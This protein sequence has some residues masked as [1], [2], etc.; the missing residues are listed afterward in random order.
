MVEQELFSHIF[1][2]CFV[3][4]QR[5][6]QV[7]SEKAVVFF[8]VRVPLYLSNCVNKQNMDYWWGTYPRKFQKRLLHGDEIIIW[9]VISADSDI[10]SYIFDDDQVFFVTITYD[11]Y[12]DMLRLFLGLNLNDDKNFLEIEILFSP[13]R[14]CSSHCKTTSGNCARDDPRAFDFVAWWWT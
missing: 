6:L 14:R 9:F 8:S 5:K 3:C 7:V 11:R 12:V 13:K 2:N 10:D 4:C 1:Q